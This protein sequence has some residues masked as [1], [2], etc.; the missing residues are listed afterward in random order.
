M[1]TFA[2]SPPIEQESGKNKHRINN[3]NTLIC[4]VLLSSIITILPYVTYIPF[5]NVAKKPWKPLSLEGKY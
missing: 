2:Q 5:Q 4:G 3:A 1:S